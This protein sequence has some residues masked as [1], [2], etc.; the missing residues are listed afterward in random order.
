MDR[1]GTGSAPR[2]IGPYSQAAAA[3]EYLFISGQIPIDP[4]T[5]EVLKGGISCIAQMK[6]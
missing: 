4:E 2:A 6:K 1:T 5:G 3:G